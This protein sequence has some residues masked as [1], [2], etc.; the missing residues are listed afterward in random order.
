[1]LIK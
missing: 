1:M